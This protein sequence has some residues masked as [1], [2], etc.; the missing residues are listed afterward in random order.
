MPK[1]SLSESEEFVEILRNML[2]SFEYFI[3]VNS[4][5]ISFREEI[6]DGQPGASVKLNILKALRNNPTI[7]N[8]ISS[9]ESNLQ[10]TFEGLG[11]EECSFFET[12][13]WSE[14]V[15]VYFLW[16]HIF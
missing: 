11:T 3:N 1:L 4:T 10:V 6:E 13:S 9:T 2:D 14:F 7:C 8:F 16:M 15:Q 12:M 5:C